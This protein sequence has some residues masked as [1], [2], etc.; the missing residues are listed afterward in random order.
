MRLQYWSSFTKINRKT[1]RHDT[2]CL[3]F[4]Y[5][6]ETA[7]IIYLSVC[8]R[9]LCVCGC[10]H[11]HLLLFSRVSCVCVPSASTPYTPFV[12]L[13]HLCD[14]LPALCLYSYIPLCLSHL[15]VPLPL[16]TFV[17][18]SLLLTV[19]VLLQYLYPYITFSLFC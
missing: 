9:P 16:Y 2:Y 11:H 3:P 13:C 4:K 10:V 14:C 1:C 6:V 8:F 7:S 15:P 12:S 19:S 18:L 5:R 17:S